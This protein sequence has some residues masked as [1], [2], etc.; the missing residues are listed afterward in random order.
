MNLHIFDKLVHTYEIGSER[1]ECYYE[2]NGANAMLR[3]SNRQ[4]VIILVTVLFY[5]I[6]EVTK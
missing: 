2:W 1:M 4:N 3:D 6:G 5:L